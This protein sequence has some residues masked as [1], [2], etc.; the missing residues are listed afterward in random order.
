MPHRRGVWRLPGALV[1][2]ACLAGGCAVLHNPGAHNRISVGVGGAGLR[3]WA[4][5]DEPPA[6]ELD[7]SGGVGVYWSYARRLTSPDRQRGLFAAAVGQIVPSAPL[8]GA[9]TLVGSC[10]LRW[11]LAAP[12]LRVQ[13]GVGYV[14]VGA[15]VVHVSRGEC[16]KDGAALAGE[17]S[18]NGATPVFGFGL[19][20]GVTSNI[21]WSIGGLVVWL[22][23]G[24][25]GLSE[26]RDWSGA[27]YTSV[28]VAF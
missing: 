4:A 1:A 20:Q 25:L 11:A 17:S 2:V 15:G 8:K 12:A 9:D 28:V 16:R 10:D 19:E 22:P 23:L 5:D 24:D 18:V 7:V 3:P 14:D 26:G 13:S 21:G 6:G 27:G